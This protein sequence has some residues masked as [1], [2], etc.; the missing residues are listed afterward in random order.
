MS[1]ILFLL[2]TAALLV[3]PSELIPSLAGMPIYLMLTVSAMACNL[4]GLHNQVRLRTLFQQPVNLCVLGVMAAVPISLIMSMMYLGG[5]YHGLLFMLK[6]ACYY[7]MLVSVINTPRRLR[8]FLMLVAISGTTLV[9]ASTLDFLAFKSKWEDNSDLPIQIEKDKL[10]PEEQRVLHHVVEVDG[11]DLLGDVTYRFRMRGFGIF[12]D[13]NDVSLLIAV[14]VIICM[15]FLT[16][17]RLSV[18]RLL[19]LIPLGVLGYGYL[20]TQSRGGLLALT[21]GFV[22]WLTMRFGK[23]TAITIGC[24]GVLA[25]PVALGR[26]AKMDLSSGS[27]QDRIQIWRDGLVQM[28]SSKLFFGIGQHQYEDVAGLVAHNSYIHAFVELGLFGGTLFF[29]CFFL[30]AYA[31]YLIKRSG[32]RIHDPELYRMLPYIAAIL[33]A[34]CVGMASLSRCY[35]LS[36]YMIAGI[37]ATYINLAGFYRSYPFPIVLLNRLTV[38]RWVVCSMGLLMSSF[39]F[40]RVFA[41]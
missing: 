36:T 41:R 40:V 6:A 13:P 2:A 10:L 17:T 20:C 31:L 26:A 15:Y 30:S 5:A 22:V 24:L 29:G 14:T 3:R 8:H 33:T 19:W 9:G 23:K 28:K 25:A 39:L 12:H 16:D 4:P 35:D 21:G 38:Q 18:F 37:C 11:Y 32:L 34:W 27:G 1:Y 7:L